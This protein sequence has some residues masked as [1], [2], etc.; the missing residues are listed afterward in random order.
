MI[1][2]KTKS[3]KM[4][5]TRHK[6]KGEIRKYVNVPDNTECSLCTKKEI[7]MDNGIVAYRGW[8]VEETSVE[9]RIGKIPNAAEY[10]RKY[11]LQSLIMQQY[12]WPIRERF[13]A[14]GPNGIHS[15]KIDE[16]IC[17]IFYK[18]VRFYRDEIF[19]SG[20]TL[21]SVEVKINREIDIP[22][23]IINA[24]FVYVPSVVG[25]VY[26]WGE[27]VECEEGYRSQFSYPK[28][29]YIEK[30]ESIPQVFTQQKIYTDL[31]DYGVSVEFFERI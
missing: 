25:E 30:H 4:V 10:V 31:L 3:G 21:S 27:I 23:T 8:N 18:N 14:K 2:T 15:V 22:N 19:F 16:N 5:C 12:H 29:L 7:I 1:M 20:N 13:E 26:I 17:N 28:K 6:G 9:N 11:R 24:L